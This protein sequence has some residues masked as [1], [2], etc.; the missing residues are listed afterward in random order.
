MYEKYMKLHKDG[1]LMYITEEVCGVAVSHVRMNLIT[2]ANVVEFTQFYTDRYKLMPIIIKNDKEY[3]AIAR[4]LI[5]EKEPV[6]AGVTKIHNTHIAIDTSS[7]IDDA[8]YRISDNFKV[9]KDARPLFN[10]V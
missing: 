1:S 9:V 7:A 4:D 3:L 2:R 5:M 10:G 6:K 8:S